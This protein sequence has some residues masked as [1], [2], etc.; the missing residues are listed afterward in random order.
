VATNVQ[1]LKLMSPEHA[2]NTLRA[3]FDPLT[4]TELE[5][6]LGEW[7]ARLIDQSAD[8]EPVTD[9]MRE[10]DTEAEKVAELLDA[11]IIDTGNTV[12]LLNAL[13]E[14]G[15]D[16]ASALTEKLQRSD[17]FYDIADDAGDVFAR[18]ANLASKTQ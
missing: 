12:A 5:V 8:Y 15:I 9:K 7:V 16:T 3:E 10:L 2:L 13:A 1:T 4:S 18:L 14:A 17:S 6:F 11:T